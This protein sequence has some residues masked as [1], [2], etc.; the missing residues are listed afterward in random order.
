MV[1]IKGMSKPRMTVSKRIVLSLEGM[2]KTGKTHFALTAP[3]PIALFNFDIGLE[4]VVH[5]FADKEILVSDVRVAKTGG[6]DMWE[7]AWDAFRKMFT[8]AIRH[9]DIRT[10]VIDNGTEM[11]ELLRLARLH[12]LTKVMP[13]QYTEVNEEFRELMRTEVF[14][15]NKNVIFVHKVKQQWVNDKFTGKYE[16][17]GFKDIGYLVQLNALSWWDDDEQEFVMTVV[18]SRHDPALIGAELRGPMLNFPTLATMIFP[19][20]RAKEW[21]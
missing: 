10:V 14:E 5:K 11:W 4:G 1:L 20:T 13:H 6:E 16:R 19:G 3:D 8:D 17:A 18:N 2:D 7:K 21:R 9:P 15:S 12:K